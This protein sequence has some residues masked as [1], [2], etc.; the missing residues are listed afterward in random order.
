MSNLNFEDIKNLYHI[1]PNDLSITGNTVLKH[2]FNIDQNYSPN[3]LNVWASYLSNYNLD[4]L[5]EAMGKLKELELKE[6]RKVYKDAFKK[7]HKKLEKVINI[8]SKNAEVETGKLDLKK[9]KPGNDSTKR[10]IAM[11]IIKGFFPDI[12][13]Q[14]NVRIYSN[15]I[16]VTHKEIQ[17]RTEKAL[18]QNMLR[19]GINNMRGPLAYETPEENAIHTQ[20]F[21]S[22]SQGKAKF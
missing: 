5:Q 18:F 4:S 10:A 9:S 8:R 17:G 6:N 12:H 20:I 16:S 7:A 22:L 19:R 13:Q 11:K 15:K 3:H 21:N 1:L 2:I 14:F